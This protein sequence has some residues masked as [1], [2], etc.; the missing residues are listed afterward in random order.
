MQ[1]RQ[2]V[3]GSSSGCLDNARPGGA[4][5]P[6]PGLSLHVED[7]VASVSPADA[8]MET[9]GMWETQIPAKITPRGKK[10]RGCGRGS[11][12]AKRRAGFECVPQ[13]FT[14]RNL[15]LKFTY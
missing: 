3:L 2:A 5:Q 7:M 4:G 12:A 15:I 1:G 11:R 9:C 10:T 8:S 13:E 6:E 14:G